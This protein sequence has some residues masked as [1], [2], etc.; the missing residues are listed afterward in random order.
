MMW[1]VRGCIISSED[2]PPHLCCFF[3][4]LYKTGVMCPN[5]LFLLSSFSSGLSHPC[6]PGLREWR[7]WDEMPSKLPH[8]LGHRSLDIKP[9]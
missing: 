7:G 4:N 1:G 5:I 6:L 8:G 9:I 2:T 3:I